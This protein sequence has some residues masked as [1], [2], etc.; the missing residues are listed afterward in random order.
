MPEPERDPVEA[1]SVDLRMPM[2]AAA[3]WA[4]ALLALR[5]PPLVAAV[6][7]VAAGLA[8]AAAAGRGRRVRAAVACLLVAAGVGAG[9]VVRTEA[10]VRDPV[11]V[12]AR[13]GAVVRAELTVTSDPVLRAGRFADH[14]VFRARA[15]SVQG[16][17]RMFVS[18]TR[19]LV[20]AEPQHAAWQLGSRI[21][22]LG[23][24]SPADDGQL[25]GVLTTRGPVSVR[26]PPGALWHASSVVRSGI[27][28]A[29]EGRPAAPRALVPA[30]V[31]GDDGGFPKGLADDF[32]TTGL[33]HLLAVSG[34]NLTLVVG[35]LV[36]LARWCG[37]R[38]RWLLL[39]AAAGIAAF[40]MIAR[41]EPS[42]V[43][44]AA[45]GTVGLISL[46]SN[47]RE[48]GTRALGLAVVALLLVDPWLAVSVGFVLSVLA[49]AG[50]LF[51]APGWRDALA[52]WLPRPLAEAVAVPA[53]AQL[54]CTPV[55]A[56]ISG[57]VSLVAVVTNLAAAPVVGPATVLG[58]LG[59]V[60]GL[61]VPPAGRLL[62]WGASWCAAW[63]I[64]VAQRGAALPT[65]AVS[66][67][68]SAVALGLLVAACV[69]LVWLLPGVL[70]RPGTGVGCCALLVLVVLVPLPTPGWPP[71][72]WV[73]VACDVGQGDGLVL[74]AGEGRAVVVDTG[75]DPRAMD[76]CLAGLGVQEIPLVVLTHFH[77]DHVDG[78]PGVLAGRPV[79]EVEV[80]ARADPLSGA[81]EVL[82]EAAGR[83]PVRVPSYGETRTV[84]DLTLQVLGP[85]PGTPTHESGEGDGSGPNNAS[86]VLLVE[87]H[88]VRLL[89]AGDVE[90]EAQRALAR[91][92]PG[93]RV[94]VLKV[95]HHGS[96][97][98]ELGWLLGLGARLAVVS[99]GADNDYGHPSPDTLAP[100]EAAGVRVLRT[101]VDGAV[102]VVVDGG[103]LGSRTRR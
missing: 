3:A 13:S 57:Q 1:G 55:V 30:L 42:V 101:D 22:V 24:L 71:Q 12:L 10:V 45:M 76:R 28:A 92:W 35:F 78:L 97:H 6:V 67:G 99:V 29:V 38:G 63:I 41:T 40:V 50:I 75:P 91:A 44:A 60:V 77:A 86:V 51:L 17:G 49:T 21:G 94:D 65:A 53:A 27:R 88:G 11:A 43:R 48:R 16:R 83:V 90:P 47:G 34:T 9:A 70:R 14:L 61:V 46:G 85:V 5:G 81:Q 79:G 18:R 96:R 62:G 20:V 23:R 39:V 4:G 25:A 74:N 52:G 8:I 100:L 66:W 87:V 80:T 102:A 26:A 32:R 56:A 89:L 68:T 31:D 82:A 64:V 37:V 59:G 93:L 7:L 103:R 73:L 19:L 58:L 72:G 54:A 15:D 98:Q 69:V 84:G 36:T 95:P 33:T 2:L